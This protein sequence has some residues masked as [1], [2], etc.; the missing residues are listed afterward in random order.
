MTQAVRA[1]VRGWIAENW[2]LDITVREWWRRLA[3]ARL[4]APAWP[5]P[6]GRDLAPSLS[7]ATAEELAAAG[8]VAPPTGVVGVGMAGPT[9][10]AHGTDAQRLRYLSPMLLGEESWCQLFSEPGAGSDLPSLTTRAVRTE[11]G[12]Q[13]TGHKLWSSGAHLARRGLLLARTERGSSGRAGIT[14]FVLDLD[15]PGVEVRPLRTMTGEAPFCEVFLDEAHIGD[16]DVVGAPGDGWRVARTTLHAERASAGDRPARGLVP[17]ASGESVG[18]LDRLTGDVCAARHDR[19]ARFSGSAVR[20]K[21][22]IALARESQVAGEAVMRQDLARYWTLTTLHRLTQG[23]AAASNAPG[24][25]GDADASGA[26]T[27]LGLSRLCRASRE[28]SFAALGAD[29]MLLGADAPH[30]GSLQVVGLSSAGVSIGAGTDEI[31]RTTIAER[32]LGLPREPS[33]TS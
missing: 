33:A 16:D 31:Q 11:G 15:Q 17:V 12:W 4:V 6:F 5:S 10:L 28:L 27:N 14:Y 21:E 7:R 26:V 13:V 18:Q 20:A 25:R 9:L 2:S 30:D 23:R 22:M 24:R 19:P 3:D 29:A 32:T 1:E 8:T